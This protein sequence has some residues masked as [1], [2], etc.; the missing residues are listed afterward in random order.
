M[1]T[2]CY[3]CGQDYTTAGCGCS[4]LG[5]DTSREADNTVNGYEATYNVTWEAAPLTELL[6]ENAELNAIIDRQQVTIAK[7]RAELN[8]VAS[9]AWPK[10]ET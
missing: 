8:E 7:L 4:T 1:A 9:L 10:D 6:R 5:G 3:Q 2:R